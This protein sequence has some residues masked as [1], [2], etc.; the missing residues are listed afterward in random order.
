MALPEYEMLHTCSS[1]VWCR[2]DSGVAVQ[3]KLYA[4]NYKKYSF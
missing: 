4:K 1:I 2:Q 3:K